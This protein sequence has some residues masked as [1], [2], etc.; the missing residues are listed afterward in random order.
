VKW[1]VN[2]GLGNYKSLVLWWVL[3]SGV[4]WDIGW[5]TCE[6]G[7]KYKK[8]LPPSFIKTRNS[9]WFLEVLGKWLIM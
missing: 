7:K 1:V 4:E 9:N 3:I 5:A 8:R 2:W 6:K